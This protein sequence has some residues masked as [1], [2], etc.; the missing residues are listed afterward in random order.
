MR[1]SGFTIIRDGVR[2]GYPFVESI[3]SLLPLVDELIVNVGDCTDETMAV[4]RSIDTDKLVIFETPWDPAMQQAGEV[5]AHQT[6][7][8][9][10]RCT[11]DWCFYIQGDEVIHEADYPK[12]KNAMKKNLAK[13]TV[14]GLMFRYLHFRG[15]YNIQDS[16]GYRKQ[17]RIV[18]NGINVRSVGDACGFGI[19]ERRLATA[20]SGARMFH[21][22]YVRPPKKMRAKD[23]QF[24]QFYIRDKNGEQINEVQDVHKIELTD[25]IYEMRACVPYRGTHPG[26]MKEH[27]SAKDWETPEY[28]YTPLWRSRAWWLGRLKKAFG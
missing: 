3:K 5:M 25:Y 8:A 22:G 11:G 12:I 23:L 15:D 1:V 24:Q 14:E 16:L 19:N 6:N 27:I 7:L 28:D 4:L 20:P 13:T 17:V 2:L 18:R 10:D 9:L 21:Y 26:I